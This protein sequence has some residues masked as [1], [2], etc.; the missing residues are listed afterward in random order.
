MINPENG[1][2]SSECSE[3]S[4]CPGSQPAQ[5]P[6]SCDAPAAL[7]LSLRPSAMMKWNKNKA[8]FRG[9]LEQETPASIQAELKFHLHAQAKY[10]VFLYSHSFSS[11]WLCP[12]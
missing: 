5:P 7:P 3:R 11:F 8:V 2:A 10:A 1:P 6:T 4:L 12:Q 9:S